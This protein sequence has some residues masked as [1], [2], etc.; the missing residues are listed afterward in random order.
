[1]IG[2]KTRYGAS[3]L[4]MDACCKGK[5]ADGSLKGRQGRYQQY[6]QEQ[7]DSMLHAEME[8][9]VMSA[10]ELRSYYGHTKRAL[11]FGSLG[12]P[13]IYDAL[14]FENRE[15]SIHFAID[16]IRKPSDGL[17]TPLAFKTD[18]TTQ[19]QGWT[20]CCIDSQYTMVGGGASFDAALD[21]S[22]NDPEGTYR[23]ENAAPLF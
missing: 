8:L 16:S 9:G 22:Y 12:M 19:E 17:A 7:L 15:K 5:K 1:M 11:D 6:G 14:R 3:L 21:K 4:L 20:P 18:E 2:D 10:H 13:C 23:P